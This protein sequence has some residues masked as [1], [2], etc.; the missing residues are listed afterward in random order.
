M[1]KK[2]CFDFRDALLVNVCLSSFNDRQGDQLQGVSSN[3]G[4][5]GTNTPLEDQQ[6]GNLSTSTLRRKLFEGSTHIQ[7]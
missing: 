7:T 5:G 1:R 6:A 4:T 3:S 2:S